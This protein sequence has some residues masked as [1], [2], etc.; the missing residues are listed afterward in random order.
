MKGNG[1]RSKLE[2]LLRSAKKKLFSFRRINRKTARC[3]P[4]KDRIKSSGKNG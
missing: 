2:T 4:I 3:K 1:S